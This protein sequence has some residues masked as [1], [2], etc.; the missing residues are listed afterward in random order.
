MKANKGRT[1]S[2]VLTTAD[3][4]RRTGLRRSTIYFYIRRGLLPEPQRKPGGH[5]L[6]SEEHVALLA[7][8]RDLKEQGN[9]LPDIRQQLGDEIAALRDSQVDLLRQQTD[10][11]RRALI[12]VAAEEFAANGYRRTSVS[13]IL[14]RLGINEHDFYRLFSSKFELLVESFRT[15]L[16]ETYGRPTGGTTPQDFGKKFLRGLV[17]DPGLHDLA[18]VFS[19]A[20]HTEGSV[21]GSRLVEAWQPIISEI[22]HDLD[23]ARPSDSPPPPIS[24]ELLAYGIMGA[25]RNVTTRASW[26]DEYDPVDVMRVQLFIVLAVHAALKDTQ[27]F[28]QL[29][30]YEGFMNELAFGLDR[31]PESFDL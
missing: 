11:L 5:A 2:E 9:A 14:E 23:N 1:I 30:Q 19:A 25:R 20:A 15:R 7:Q 16:E 18:A 28:A 6:Y 24:W 26:D 10:A 3:L 29:E 22:V 13:T 4:E 17:N 27:V 21:D 12:D 31:V 8:I